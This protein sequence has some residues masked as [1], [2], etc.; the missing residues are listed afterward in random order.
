MTQPVILTHANSIQI[1]VVRRS[2]GAMR[3]ACSAVGVL[4]R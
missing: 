4:L 2:I 3:F 1:G